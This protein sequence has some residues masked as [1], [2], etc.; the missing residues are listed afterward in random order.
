MMKKNLFVNDNVWEAGKRFPMNLQ[1]FAEP[2]PEP[3]PEPNSDSDPEPDPDSDP[4]P[5]DDKKEYTQ[6]EIDTIVAR[7]VRTGKRQ[8]LD[9]LGIKDKKVAADTLADIKKYLD[10]KETPEQK[11]A[12]E[13]KQKEVDAANERA[14]RAEAK[15]IALSLGA[16][17]EYIDDI[18]TIAMSKKKDDEEIED[19]LKE[20]KT[21]YAAF[22]DDE[23]DENG[24][25]VNGAKKDGTGRGTKGGSKR[26]QQ[27]KSFAAQIA[28]K[29]YE[30]TGKNSFFTRT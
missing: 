23:E 22:F 30:G 11:V 20:M 12:R 27:N 29:K 8:I 19:V 16:K 28:K 15:V 21:K 18:L 13:E 7:A 17:K 3:D 25:G 6:K 2:N 26:N 9:M 1:L 24:D 10:S 5:K 14:E 4:E